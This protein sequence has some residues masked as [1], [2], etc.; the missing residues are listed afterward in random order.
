MEGKAWHLMVVIWCCV[1]S[2]ISD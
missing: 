1:R 2:L